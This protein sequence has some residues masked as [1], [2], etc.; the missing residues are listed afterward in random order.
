[1]DKTHIAD[2]ETLERVAVALESMGAST[3]PIF[4]AE[5]GRYTNASLAAW[6]AKMRD[7]KNY[8]V[9][10]PKGSAT[11]CTKTGV[12]AGI[13]NPKPGVIGRA[14]IDPYVNHGAFI[15]F[16]VNGGVDA[17]GTP[18]V[19]AI[20]GDG[21]FSRKDDTWIMTPVLYTLETETDDAVNLTVSDTQNQGMKSQPAA[22]LPNGAKRPY[23]LYAKYALSV[24]ADG[25]PRSVSGAPV[26]TRSVSHDGGIGLMKTAATGDALKVAADDWYV[27][28]MFLL[29]YATKNSQSVFA[30]CTGHTEQCNPTLAES[31][32]TRV[33]IKKATADAIPVGSAMMFGTHTGT[34][35]DRGTDYNYDIFDGAKVLK[36]VAVDDSNTALYF[37]VAKPFNVETTYYLSTA[38][39]NTGACDMVEGDGSPT[40]CTSG[41]EPFVMQGIELGLGMYEVLGNV[42]IQYTGSGTVVWVNPDTKNEKSGDLASGALSCGAFPGPATEGW[43]YGLYPKT[44]SGLMMQQGTGASTSVGVCDGNY[45]VADTTVG[46]REWL[47]LGDVWDWGNAGLW[48]VAGNYGTGVARWNF[49]SRRSANGRSRGE[50]A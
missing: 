36:K 21:R 3:V 47:S 33:V 19:T 17:D 50:A 38:P 23:M 11:T 20:D 25:K 46:W 49:G 10:I 32:T 2:H 35:T 6:L 16:E 12:N 29:K 37:D 15:F 48:Y 42:L 24:D 30:G 1:M 18:Y 28:A 43:N 31:N 27:K 9:S 44:V 40:S 26:K 8:G 13:A 14:A 7:G 4:D 39:W 22:Y 41:R 45:K 5:T 34:S